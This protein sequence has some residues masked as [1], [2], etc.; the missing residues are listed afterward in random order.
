MKP[1]PTTIKECHETIRL[2]LNKLDEVSKRLDILEVENKKLKLE[3]MQLKER[4]NM[5]SLNSSLS[6]SKSLKKK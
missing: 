2:L 6:P 4:L 5:N 1:F 3:N